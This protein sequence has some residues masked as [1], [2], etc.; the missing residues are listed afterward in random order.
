MAKSHPDIHTINWLIRLHKDNQLDFTLAIQRK[1]VWDAER[2]SNL[3]ASILWGCTIDGILFEED[4]DDGYFVLEGKQRCTT[5]IR[6]VNNE[7]PISSKCHCATAKNGEPIIGKKF[8]ELSLKLQSMILERELTFSICRPMSED[9]RALEFFMRN[10]GMPLSKTQLLK[11]H[12]GQK[13]LDSLKSLI[14]HPLMA[15]L[16]LSD[17]KTEQDL[18]VVMECLIQESGQ[19]ISFSG[20]DVTSF[21]KRLHSDGSPLKSIL[22]V[23]QVFDYLDKAIQDKFKLRKLHVSTIY[24]VARKALKHKIPEDKFLD[25][26]TSFF[27]NNKGVDNEYTKACDKG[28]LKKASINARVKF[29]TSDFDATFSL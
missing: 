21:A 14:N 28:V 3:I 19:D 5:I 6:F 10:Q 25:W 1:E 22:Y 29:M 12:L 13:V 7:F 2:K 17:S 15:K 18:Q 26:M 8:S 27:K 24:I 16:G 20:D 23:N 4:G 9:E 11:G